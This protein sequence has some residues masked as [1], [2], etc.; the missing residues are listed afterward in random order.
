MY[1]AGT[2]HPNKAPAVAFLNRVAAG[3]V[4]AVIDAE[5]LQEILHRYRALHRW[6]EGERVFELARGIF[7]DVLAITAEVMDEACRILSLD[8]SL[9]ARDA[10]HAA[11]VAVYA[12]EGICSFDKDFDRIPGCPRVVI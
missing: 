2:D 1:A 11:V 3:Q 6:A 10:V 7:P 4:D 5:A 12:L 9:T 8:Q